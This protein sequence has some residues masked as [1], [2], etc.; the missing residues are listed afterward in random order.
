MNTRGDQMKLLDHEAVNAKAG[1]RSKC[2]RW[3]D[4]N[5]GTFP[6]PVK[7]GSRLMWVEEEI[8]RWIEARIRAR[9]AQA[10]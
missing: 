9:D 5:A 7:I 3:R 1:P 4:V 6:K 2:Q 8:D 10:A